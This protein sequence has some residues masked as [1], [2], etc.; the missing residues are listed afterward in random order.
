MQREGSTGSRFR[1]VPAAVRETLALS[2]VLVSA[3][4]TTIGL[5]LTRARVT[6][7]IPPPL[8]EGAGALAAVSCGEWAAGSDVS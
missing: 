8:A 4:S 3:S 2:T 5:L 6:G 1:G 7:K